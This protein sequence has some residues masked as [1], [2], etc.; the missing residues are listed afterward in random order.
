MLESVALREEFVVEEGAVGELGDPP[1]AVELTAIN[2]SN[3]R[4]W[5]LAVLML[6]RIKWSVVT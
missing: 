6:V 5:D 1:Q 2:V 4:P 3:Q